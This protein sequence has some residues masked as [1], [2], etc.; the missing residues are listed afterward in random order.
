M[1]AARTINLAAAVAEAAKIHVVVSGCPRTKKNHGIITTRGGRPRMFPSRP[2]TEWSKSATI[3]VNGN[4]LLLLED[5]GLIVRT[6]S[7]SRMW[8]P[9][10]RPLNCT[11]LFYSDR[12]GG[13]LIG[14]LQGL[15]DLLQHRG[16]IANDRQLVGF[17]GSRLLKDAANPRTEIVLT[18]AA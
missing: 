6:P 1:R 5:V 15:G 17:D 2:W 12:L 7:R 14:F 10:E 16:V 4:P 3:T 9:L 8:Q 18:E 13:D 11:A